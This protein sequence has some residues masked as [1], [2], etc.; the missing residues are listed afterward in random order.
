MDCCDKQESYPPIGLTRIILGTVTDISTRDAVLKLYE[1]L[2]A[3]GA[4]HGDI[5][6]RHMRRG[7]RPPEPVASTGFGFPA[8][9]PVPV[10]PAAIRLIDFD[11]STVPLGRFSN[12]QWETSVGLELRK[13]RSEFRIAIECWKRVQYSAGLRKEM[14]F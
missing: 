12:D 3:A 1:K 5:D 14:D 6:R 8:P 9:T 7:D 10:N 4:V 11:H 13:V 2:H